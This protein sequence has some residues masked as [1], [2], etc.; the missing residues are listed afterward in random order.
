MGFARPEKV[1]PAL[2]PGFQFGLVAEQALLDKIFTAASL[3]TNDLGLTLTKIGVVVSTLGPEPWSSGES[4]DQVEV[5]KP[6]RSALNVADGVGLQKGVN[7]FASLTFPTSGLY[8]KTDKHVVKLP[9]G[10][11][12]A[13]GF[14]GKQYAQWTA[15]L[16]VDMDVPQLEIPT[17]G[18]D[19]IDN[20]EAQFG[21]KLLTQGAA[22]PLTLMLRVSFDLVASEWPCPLKIV[23]ELDIDELGVMASASAIGT[24][25]NAFG[26]QGLDLTDLAFVLGFAWADEL[27]T[28]G[29]T[30][31]LDCGQ[32]QGFLAVLFDAE[33]PTESMFAGCVSDV[34]LADVVTAILGSG[35]MDSAIGGILRDAF[36]I[37]GIALTQDLPSAN[38][39]DEA[40]LDSG[41][42]PSSIKTALTNN[43]QPFATTDA[44]VSVYTS[45]KDQTWFL[46]DH[47]NVNGYTIGVDQG[48]FTIEWQAEIYIAPQATRIGQFRFPAGRRVDARVK[49]LDIVDLFAL[50]EVRET[51]SPGIAS[52][53]EMERIELFDGLLT[54]SAPTDLA[55]YQDFGKQ[56]YG[57]GAQQKAAAYKE[58][59]M[60]S[61][62]SFAEAIGHST[63]GPGPVYSTATYSDPKRYTNIQN[64]KIRDL[65]QAPHVLFAAGLNL[66]GHV[67]AELLIEITTSGLEFELELEIEGVQATL[68]CYLGTDGFS[69]TCD[70][71]LTFSD[72]DLGSPAVGPSDNQQQLWH[73]KT[74]DVEVGVGFTITL[75]DGEQSIEFHLFVELFGLEMPLDF[76][77]TSNL[78]L[79]NL[80]DQIR[81]YIEDHIGDLFKGLAG[82]ERWL[83]AVVGDYLRYGPPADQARIL[84]AYAQDGAIAAEQLGAVCHML[85]VAWTD[86]KDLFTGD[87]TQLGKDVEAQFGFHVKQIGLLQRG[88]PTT[89]LPDHKIATVEKWF[90][91]NVGGQLGQKTTDLSAFYQGNRQWLT[92]LQTQFLEVISINPMLFDPSD[93]GM[94]LKVQFGDIDLEL[95]MEYHRISADLGVFSID[96]SEMHRKYV[97]GPFSFTLPALLIDIY[98]NG[99][100][101]LDAGF[102]QGD[103]WSRA[104]HVSVLSSGP[105]LQ[106]T[107]GFYIAELGNATTHELSGDVVLSAGL[108]VRFGV[109]DTVSIGIM[110]GGYRLGFAGLIEGAVGF[111]GGEGA[112]SDLAPVSYH[113]N[114]HLTISGS[115]WGKVDFGLVKASVALTISSVVGL[116]VD[117]TQGD[118]DLSFECHIKARASLTIGCGL[119]KVHL[120]FSFSADFHF[121]LTLHVPLLG[122]EAAYA[123]AA[124]APRLPAGGG[125]MVAGPELAAVEPTPE[126]TL[127]EASEKLDAVGDWLGKNQPLTVYFYP[128]WSVTF[129]ANGAGKLQLIGAFGTDAD[130]FNCVVHYLLHVVF[131]MRQ[132][133]YTTGSSIPLATLETLKDDLDRDMWNW[134][135]RESKWQLDFGKRMR[136]Y[137]LCHVDQWSYRTPPQEPTELYWFPPDPNLRMTWGSSDNRFRGEA[138]FSEVNLLR[139]WEY[140]EMCGWFAQELGESPPAVDP[141]READAPYEHPTFASMVYSSYCAFLIRNGIRVVIDHVKQGQPCNRGNIAGMDFSEVGKQ[142]SL[143]FRHGLRMP[144]Q[145]KAFYSLLG[146]QFEYVPYLI[147]AANDFILGLAK[148]TR[149]FSPYSQR[150]YDYEILLAEKFYDLKGDNALANKFRGIASVLAS[151]DLRTPETGIED[152]TFLPAA[153]SHP[154]R[155]G[156]P[157]FATW[158]ASPSATPASFL[159][160][161]SLAARAAAAAGKDVTVVLKQRPWSDSSNPIPV[162]LAAPPDPHVQDVQGTCQWACR[163][164]LRVRKLHSGSQNVFW[165]VGVPAQQLTALAAVRKALDSE[166]LNT[167]DI[168]RAPS[169]GEVTANSNLAGSLVSHPTVDAFVLRLGPVADVDRDHTIAVA[170]SKNNAADFLAIVH[171]ASLQSR[172][173]AVISFAEATLGAEVFKGRSV[174]EVELLLTSDP[175]PTSSVSDAPFPPWANTVCLGGLPAGTTPANTAFF[176]EDQDPLHLSWESV[177]HPGEHAMG[178]SRDAPVEPHEEPTNALGVKMLAASSGSL[179][180]IKAGDESVWQWDADAENWYKIGVNARS[181]AADGDLLCKIDSYLTTVS[182]YTVTLRSWEKICHEHHSLIAAGCGDLYRVSGGYCIKGTWQVAPPA[183]SIAVGAADQLYTVSIPQPGTVW[184]ID[185][186]SDS[187][188]RPTEKTRI[189]SQNDATAVF[190]DSHDNVYI[191]VKAKPYNRILKYLGTKDSWVQ[192]GE[193]ASSL[194]IGQADRFFFV[195]SR[196]VGTV[197]AVDTSVTPANAEC[198]YPDPKTHARSVVT[199]GDNLYRVD[200]DSTVWKYS[201]T[202]DAWVQLGVAPAEIDPFELQHNQYMLDNAYS[203]LSVTAHF[204]PDESGNLVPKPLRP[205]GPQRKSDDDP[206]WHYLV[207]VPTGPELTADSNPYEKIG[208]SL[209]REMEIEAEMRDV[210]GNVLE[211]SPQWLDF[212]LEYRDRL[213]SVS[214]WPGVGLSYS[215]GTR[216][217]WSIHAVLTPCEKIKQQLE[218]DEK[219]RHAAF[220]LLELASWQVHRDEQ[221]RDAQI[222]L[223]ISL[224]TPHWDAENRQVLTDAS[225]IKQSTGFRTFR[226]FTSEMGLWINDDPRQPQAPDPLGLRWCHKD[227]PAVPT[228][229]TAL[230]VWLSIA[231][232]AHVD[233]EA[234]DKIPEVKSVAAEIPPPPATEATNTAFEKAFAGLTLGKAKPP[235]QKSGLW[236]VP[237]PLL[238]FKSSDDTPVYFAAQPISN[239]L[240]SGTAYLPADLGMNAHPSDWSDSVP[241][242]YSDVDAALLAQELFE[243]VDAVLSPETS[244]AAYE[245]DP[246]ATAALLS[247]HD[248]VAALFAKR[249]FGRLFEE[250]KKAALGDPHAARQW[251]TD[252]LE[253][254]LEAAYNVDVVVQVKLTWESVSLPT[255]RQFRLHGSVTSTREGSDFRP[256][257]AAVTLKQEGTGGSSGWLTFSFQDPSDV[258]TQN[259]GS[260]ELYFME[261]LQFEASHLEVIP[262][263]DADPVW[264]QLVQPVTKHLLPVGIE[265]VQPGDFYLPIVR[266]LYPIPPTLVSQSWEPT[267]D[268]DTVT[269]DLHPFSELLDWT[270]RFQLEV[271]DTAQDEVRVAFDL[272]GDKPGSQ[273]DVVPDDKSDTVSIVAAL[274]RAHFGLQ[275]LRAD[276]SLT[277]LLN[278]GSQKETPKPAQRAKADQA[279]KGLAT[280]L[281]YVVRNTTWKGTPRPDPPASSLDDTYE[282]RTTAVG[283]HRYDVKLRPIIASDTVPEDIEKQSHELAKLV[284]VK[285]DVPKETDSQTSQLA[286]DQIGATSYYRYYQKLEYTTMEQRK[287]LRREIDRTTLDILKHDRLAARVHLVRNADLMP[288]GKNLTTRAAYLF[289]TP[290]MGFAK[291]VTPGLDAHALT[292]PVTSLGLSDTTPTDVEGWT[293]RLLDLIFKQGDDQPQL[294]RVEVRYG[295]EAVAGQAK[296]TVTVPVVMSLLPEE[297]TTPSDAA[298]LAQSIAEGIGNWKESTSD[299]RPDGFLEFEIVVFGKPGAGTILFRSPEIRLP[300]SQLTSL[301]T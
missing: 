109:Q 138:D 64:K 204:P 191:L 168:L 98:T 279:L 292:Y 19:R 4:A 220:Q 179:Y 73:D 219:A 160:D 143:H 68:D 192:V 2:L 12:Q 11:L 271:N 212:P 144:P 154:V 232:T 174:G 181:L 66:L 31:L 79:V 251:F 96:T 247:E 291:P 211:P 294:I 275:A 289:S 162:G 53:V 265:V 78:S 137:V 30:G 167:L 27:P 116:L 250:Q 163:L 253:R 151:K 46:F 29:F 110:S 299:L 108:A 148:S 252:M 205:V 24:W 101:K 3:S 136:A 123:L 236:V 264:I 134:L 91:D 105:A 209:G 166:E 266:R 237:K 242:H 38:E 51:P 268:V 135:G 5:P 54:L 15:G 255:D 199:D 100:F 238:D 102:P 240:E 159:L 224:D 70:V 190:A 120:H 171:T 202:G 75:K 272:G 150:R 69:A 184:Q 145:N 300:L 257:I 216:R 6:L 76:S 34:S 259:R 164:P 185:T 287:W 288:G 278:L 45:E 227:T 111:G 37:Q 298:K 283:P 127:V 249:Q 1:G 23:G 182:A 28:V 262:Q 26:V 280:L 112:L 187:P 233:S 261:A 203:I 225:K 223:S 218:N 89:A 107:G 16:F 56:L 169:Q 152:L 118:V 201:G 35:T 61:A 176:A 267:I 17:F 157:K 231:R 175:I 103:D 214:E 36:S 65:L 99:N 71:R 239:V 161:A 180:A 32:L 106:G 62:W 194:A 200:V 188:G 243:V 149:S 229:P 20:L 7:F 8:H 269:S 21:I 208:V 90:A 295:F 128:E 50:I 104:M 117:S 156:L 146:S 197:W 235:G 124:P 44:A 141:W 72:L 147:S 132:K 119:F 285:V 158:Y 122:G 282:L 286:K 284:V 222:Y 198:I 230:R 86:L 139:R 301:T 196:D 13:V 33:N 41:R 226:T 55:A 114:G 22:T 246:T 88:G 43:D 142:V 276:G 165:I 210:Y 93:Y 296:S 273:E 125:A 82:V 81:Q 83:A 263:G 129:D 248:K 59:G 234:A 221:H 84:A 42:V 25:E 172:M 60:T 256:A 254:S 130:A 153:V 133:S 215:F 121:S 213:F 241:H 178:F 94:D 228:V 95:E 217:T 85:G 40:I 260:D 58:A 293:K 277:T 18:D 206:Q 67:E 126:M 173:T 281:G 52:F 177:A 207:N 131:A 87:F 195:S 57:P 97:L 10:E 170:G 193:G 47:Q 244:T 140:E 80:G 92:L 48:T 14:F 63:D 290:P 183:S 258:R 155:Y 9:T 74:E 189:Y 297:P 245:I 186:S 113:I 274:A 39:A 115:L 77:W 270:Y 49:I